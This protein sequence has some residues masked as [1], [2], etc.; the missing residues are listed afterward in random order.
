MK[1]RFL[2]LVAIL[3][4]MCWASLPAAA[5]ISFTDLISTA[6]FDLSGSTLTVVLTD[7]NPANEAS[8]AE[9]LTALFWNNANSLTKVSALVTA[10]SNVIQFGSNPTDL[11]TENA[12]KSY[13][14]YSDAKNY[15]PRR[16]EAHP[17]VP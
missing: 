14:N 17:L 7:N 5:S 12:Y 11:G 6:T 8:D 13:Q 4:V 2:V 1:K 3:A 9:L 16:R 10:G 15:D